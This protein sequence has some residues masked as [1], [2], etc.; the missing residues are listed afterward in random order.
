MLCGFVEAICERQADRERERERPGPTQRPRP[1]P[2]DLETNTDLQASIT[3]VC[4]N[5]MAM[6]RWQDS[7]VVHRLSDYVLILQVDLKHLEGSS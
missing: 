2:R 3:V 7:E 1:R 5:S 6:S 4:Y